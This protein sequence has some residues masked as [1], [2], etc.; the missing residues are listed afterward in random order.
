MPKHATPAAVRALGYARVST[1]GQ[2]ADGVSLDAQRAKIVAM[3]S[4]QDLQ[5]VEQLPHS[6]AD[7]T[8]FGERSRSRVRNPW[9]TDTKVTWWCQPG[10]PRPSK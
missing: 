5:L 10:Q 4:L 8:S 9:A 6:Q 7:A 3:A 2:A 1:S